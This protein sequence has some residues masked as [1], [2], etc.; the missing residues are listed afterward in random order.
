MTQGDLE[1]ESV[2][3]TCPT[4]A[5]LLAYVHGSLRPDEVRELL[6]HVAGCQRCSDAVDAVALE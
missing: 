5:L 2:Q 6:F 1:E 3:R 4:T